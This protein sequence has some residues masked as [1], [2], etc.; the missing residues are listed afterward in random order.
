MADRRLPGGYG[1]RQGEDAYIGNSESLLLR[2]ALLPKEDGW[3]LSNLDPYFITTSATIATANRIRFYYL[4]VPNKNYTL[5]SCRIGCATGIASSVVRCA[6]YQYRV[7][8]TGRKLF[9]IPGTKVSFDTATA[10]LLE[11]ELPFKVTIGA[12]E[13]IFFAVQG[14]DATSALSATTRFADRP[15]LNCLRAAGYTDLPASLTIGELTKD[16]DDPVFQVSYLS[17]EAALV[18]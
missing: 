10:G 12:G 13:H 14:S 3:L 11:R 16:A 7:D 15:G 2:Q 18:I 4:Q 5:S 1:Q 8:Q 6:I 17:Q 9:L